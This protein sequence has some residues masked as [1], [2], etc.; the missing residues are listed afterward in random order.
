MSTM[1]PAFANQELPVELASLL[2]IFDV[3]QRESSDPTALALLVYVIPNPRW[4][5]TTQNAPSLAGAEWPKNEHQTW[6]SWST[7]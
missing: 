2:Q 4:A 6:L 7:T 1:N 3:Q 5:V